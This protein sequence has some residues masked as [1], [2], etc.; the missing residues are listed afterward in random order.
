MYRLENAYFIEVN[1]VPVFHREP[2]QGITYWYDEHP[3]GIL[4]HYTA[5]CNNDI[6]GTIQAKGFGAQF[7]VGQDGSIYEYVA[8]GLAT[9][10][11]YEA[12]H[13]YWGI[14]HTAYPGHC[15]LTD[16]QLEA[17]AKL[18][19][20]LVEFTADNWGFE[21]P[22][23]KVQ[24][25]VGF[26][27]PPGFLDHRDGTTATWNQNTHTD[28]LYRWTWDEY[29]A[30]VSYYLEGDV[31]EV[32]K[33]SMAFRAGEPL[34]ADASRGFE[35]GWHLEE[36]IDRAMKNPKSVPST[37]IPEHQHSATLVGSVTVGPV[38]RS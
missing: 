6:A 35:F 14:E 27:L 31:E 36:R 34:P 32:F 9:W 26:E 19:A 28:H 25:P 20:A 30:R 2:N 10:H 22:L 15:E 18:A 11:A 33:G 23:V 17:S 4:W 7:C 12:S 5:G 24:P 21:I 37:D 16:V 38:V 8:L 3:R 29:L 13:T 1:G